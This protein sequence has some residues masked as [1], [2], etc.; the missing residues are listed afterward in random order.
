MVPRKKAI[1]GCRKRGV[2]M[3]RRILWWA[4]GAVILLNGACAA[5]DDPQV[6]VQVTSGEAPA[7]VSVD[8]GFFYDQLAPYGDWIQAEPYGWVWYP[9]NTPAGWRPYTYG[10]WVYTDDHGWVWDSNWDWG[11]ACFHYG[12]WA[13]N[14]SYGWVWVPGYDWGPAWVAWRSG[15]GYVGWAPLPPEIRWHAGIGLELGQHDL[16]RDIRDRDWIFV[17][18][19]DFDRPALHYYVLPSWRNGLLFE[20]TQ[21]VT[22]LDIVAGHIM[23]FGI[24]IGAVERATGRPVP[25]YHLRSVGSL[26]AARLP[27]ERRGELDVFRPRIMAGQPGLRPPERGI[28]R[29]QEFERRRMQEQQ[30][31]ERAFQQRQQEAERQARGANREELQRRQETEQ[32]ALRGEHERQSRQ[33]ENRQR[34]ERERFQPQ[35]E[36]RA[37]RQQP[38][39]RAQEQRSREERQR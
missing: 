14:D 12:R 38:E 25:H 22:R 13:M 3:N 32:Q 30:E 33:F 9:Y 29:G 10:Q 23:D 26:G 37:E 28:E 8:I 21:N 31:A 27:R 20:H 7:G 24:S 11:W 19:R 2:V 16:D 1:I 5:P 17:P 39:R 36:P 4:T 15:P 6:G 18:D 35:P 34:R